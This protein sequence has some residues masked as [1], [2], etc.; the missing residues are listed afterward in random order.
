[1]QET[2]KVL[3]M[4]A[5]EDRNSNCSFLGRERFTDPKQKEVAPMLVNP[6]KGVNDMSGELDCLD[7]LVRI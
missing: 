3:T 4:K 5:L 1:M 7:L 6:V 2:G